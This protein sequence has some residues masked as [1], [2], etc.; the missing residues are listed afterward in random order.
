[1]LLNVNALQANK[2]W[3]AVTARPVSEYTNVLSAGAAVQILFA[4]LYQIYCKLQ[5]EEL[6]SWQHLHTEVLHRLNKFHLQHLAL[7]KSEFISLDLVFFFYWNPYQSASE[8]RVH[9]WVF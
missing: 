2:T 5:L 3:C 4:R 6:E 1:M 9:I 8:M 7:N